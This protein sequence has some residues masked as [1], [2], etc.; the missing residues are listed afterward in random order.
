MIEPGKFDPEKRVEPEFCSLFRFRAQALPLLPSP[1][2]HQ[3]MRV[4]LKW[5][6]IA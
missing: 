4:T 2:G 5:R 1:A 3:P 6:T